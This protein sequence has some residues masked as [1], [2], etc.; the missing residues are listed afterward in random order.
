GRFGSGDERSILN[1]PLETVGGP[2]LGLQWA[3]VCNTPY[4][5]YKHFVHEGGA[6]TPFIA[7]W[8]AGV[9]AADRG[10]FVR[11]YAY[12]QDVMAT[13]LELSGAEYPETAPPHA[14]RSFAPLLAGARTPIHTEP[15]FWEHEGN[16]AVRRGDWKLV[17]EY[18]KP[19]ELYQI[20]EDPTELN[21]LSQSEPELREELITLW[22]NWATET[23]VSFPKRFIMSDALKQRQRQRQQR[24]G[25]G[26][27]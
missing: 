1:P 21:D 18:R 4:R 27:P 9:P 13:L 15:L 2:R 26:T 17:R 16:A 25:G 6:R 8:P 14:G 22:E 11:E 23:G 19:W 5:K 20:R 7:H 12:L 10:G 24:T 3:G